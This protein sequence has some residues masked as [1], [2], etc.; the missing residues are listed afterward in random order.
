MR[1]TRQMRGALFS[2]LPSEAV[3]DSL[4]WSVVAAVAEAMPSAA[5]EGKRT[6]V[7]QDDAVQAPVK[8]RQCSCPNLN[9]HERH[10][11]CFPS[12]LRKARSAFLLR[13]AHG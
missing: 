8:H 5:M 11:A 6:P 1:W 3:S 12:L 7:R 13:F 9:L 2:I 10:R 4:W